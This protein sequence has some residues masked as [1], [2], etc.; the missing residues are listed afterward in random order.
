MSNFNNIL[1]VS[2]IGALSLI[3]YVTSIEGS[4]MHK[5][6]TSDNEIAILGSDRRQDRR[7]DRQDRRDDRR[8]NDV[9]TTEMPSTQSPG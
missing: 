9:Q 1:K 4:T 5:Q 7:D 6:A 3:P 8:G 2:L